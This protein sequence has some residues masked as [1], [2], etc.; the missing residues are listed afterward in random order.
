MFWSVG[1]LGA[2]SVWK[3]C[4][5]IIK[6]KSKWKNS[7]WKLKDYFTKILRTIRPWLKWKL[8]L[9]M[10]I[11]KCKKM[12]WNDKKK[13]R[14]KR[15][16]GSNGKC[17]RLTYENVSGDEMREMPSVELKMGNKKRLN[18]KKTKFVLHFK[19]CGGEI[20]HLCNRLHV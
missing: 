11:S 20:N 10:Q 4:L 7:N 6:F 9:K 3:I 2:S 12:I 15:F 17:W 16:R 8:K 14:F 19:T 1:A 5:I 13:V 18:G